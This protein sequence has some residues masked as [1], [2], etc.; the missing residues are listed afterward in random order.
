M[1][2]LKRR[3]NERVRLAWPDGRAV[4]VEV[5]GIDGGRV[6]LAFD[7]PWDVR[8]D[9]EERITRPEEPTNVLAD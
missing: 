8:I 3:R 5:A 1:L 7:A 9:R 4:W 6:R 2:V